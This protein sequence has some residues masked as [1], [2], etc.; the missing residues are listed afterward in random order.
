MLKDILK[1]LEVTKVAC[2]KET[3][4]FTAVILAV[5]PSED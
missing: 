4:K 5:K 3:E 2:N 1:K